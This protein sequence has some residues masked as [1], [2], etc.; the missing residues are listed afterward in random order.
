MALQLVDKAGG[1][2]VT[3]VSMAPNDEVSGLRTALAMGAAK[4]ILVS[5][6]ALHGADAPDHRQGARQ[7]RRAGRRRR[8]GH[9]RDRGDRR[10][11]RHDPGAGRRAPRLAVAHVR[12]GDRD[13]GRQG[14]GAAPDR[15]GLRRG[16]GAAARGRERDRRCGRA[17]L[18]LVQGDHGGEEQAGRPGDR[19]PT[20]ASAP[21]TSR[22]TRRSCPSRLRPPARPARRSRT[23]ATRTSASS[24]FLEQLKVI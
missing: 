20:S 3:L 8:P 14:E 19:R 13:R 7:V 24:Q 5:D 1:G 22:R 9:H 12:Q 6:D 15:G 17:P 11:H 16:R 23:T 4:A 10:V 18:P 2:E 21:T